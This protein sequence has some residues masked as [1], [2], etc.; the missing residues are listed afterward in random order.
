M[1]HGISSRQM[2]ALLRAP[3]KIRIGIQC[4]WFG[5][6]VLLFVET[7]NRC[8]WAQSQQDQPVTKQGQE[9]VSPVDGEPSPEE[10]KIAAEAE[11]KARREAR[12]VAEC[13]R[14]VSVA[15]GKVAKPEIFPEIS[16]KDHRQQHCS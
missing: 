13:Q 5:V 6:A 8:A 14:L 12:A 1:N 11:E 2:L 3:V 16:S 4:C 15:I 7:C 9:V 10:A